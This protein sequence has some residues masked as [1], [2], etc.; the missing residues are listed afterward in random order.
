MKARIVTQVRIR[1]HRIDRM[2]K[3]KRMRTNEGAEI[4]HGLIPIDAPRSI[5]L[6]LAISGLLWAAIFIAITW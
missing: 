6:A 1:H 5:L 2:P 4:L 3:F